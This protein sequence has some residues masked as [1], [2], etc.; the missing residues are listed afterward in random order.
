MLATVQPA[1]ALEFMARAE[2]RKKAME[3]VSQ[4]EHVRQ[5]KHLLHI[6]TFVA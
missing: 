1:A 6:R 2:V 4:L 3:I 5:I